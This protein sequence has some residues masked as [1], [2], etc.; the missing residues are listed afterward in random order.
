MSNPDAIFLDTGILLAL[1]NSKE[2]EIADK[3]L[4]HL[5]PFPHAARL[6]TTPCL[7]ELFYKLR[8]LLSPK[9]THAGLETFGI[10]LLAH[11]PAFEKKVFKDY[12]LINHPNS[13]DYAD[14]FLCRSALLFP[15]SLIL[16]IDR[17]DFPNAFG[18]A[19]KDREYKDHNDTR[20][21]A[22]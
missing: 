3:A 5:E 4:N 18:M 1:F 7:V 6:V 17:N 13:F 2:Q 11:D 15:H 20:I 19:Y 9:D 21:V 16:T 22:I 8:K 10:E 12:C 14:Y